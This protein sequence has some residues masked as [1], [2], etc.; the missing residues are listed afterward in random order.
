[1]YPEILNFAGLRLVFIN[2]ILNKNNNNY[3]FQVPWFPMLP[4]TVLEQVFAEYTF[5]VEQEVRPSII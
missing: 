1:M 2:Y 4:D 3:Q 5:V